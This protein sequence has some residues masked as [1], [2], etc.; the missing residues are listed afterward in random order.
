MCSEQH[1]RDMLAA[2]R[3]QVDNGYSAESA[4]ARICDNYQPADS[5]DVDKLRHDAAD[6]ESQTYGLEY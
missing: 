5:I 1:Y 3:R 6:Y 4:L 2:V